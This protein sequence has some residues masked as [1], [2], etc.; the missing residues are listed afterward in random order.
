MIG[1]IRT[2]VDLN[3][4][5]RKDLWDECWQKY[6]SESEQRNSLQMFDSSHVKRNR[7]FVDI[8]KNLISIKDLPTFSI[9]TPKQEQWEQPNRGED[10]LL[11]V[12]LRILEDKSHC[13]CSEDLLLLGFSFL[14]WVR[15]CLYVCLHGFFHMDY[16]YLVL[17]DNSIYQKHI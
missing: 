11:N 2:H 6:I 8:F 14:P 17:V 16:F 4:I 15:V 1:W 7:I 9:F 5:L 12:G 3:D 13:S 10:Y